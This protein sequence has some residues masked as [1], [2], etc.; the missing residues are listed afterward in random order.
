MVFSFQHVYSLATLAII[1]H[2]FLATDDGARQVALDRGDNPISPSV[3]HPLNIRYRFHDCPTRPNFP[4]SPIEFAKIYFCF[5]LILVIV[6][7][8][9]IQEIRTTDMI[10]VESI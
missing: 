3:H 8:Y 9:D 5:F 7:P 4:T 6:K 10:N 1:F 2:Y